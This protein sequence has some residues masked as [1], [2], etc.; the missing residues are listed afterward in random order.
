MSIVYTVGLYWIRLQHLTAFSNSF[1]ITIFLIF[2]PYL[3]TLHRPKCVDQ[4][5]RKL[6]YIEHEKTRKIHKQIASNVYRNHK[7]HR[8][9]SWRESK[10]KKK[11]DSFCD[12]IELT[13]LLYF[14]FKHSLNRAHAHRTFLNRNLLR[15]F[16]YHQIVAGFSESAMFDNYITSLQI[17]VYCVGKSHFQKSLHLFNT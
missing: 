3:R 1:K 2:F 12:S 4:F 6:R 7:C 16:K 5:R 9:N 8:C 14:D 15:M 17:R 13:V 11:T 10:E